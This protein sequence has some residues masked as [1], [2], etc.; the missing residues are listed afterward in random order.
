MDI[1]KY[2]KWNKPYKYLLNIV[3]VYSRYAWS[4]PIKSKDGKL[5]SEIIDEILEEIRKI[6]PHSPITITT[7]LGSEFVNSNMTDLIEKH[8][9]WKHYTIIVIL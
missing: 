5:I 7:D 2:Y 1:S 6:F 4:Y 3:D 8:H 9:V